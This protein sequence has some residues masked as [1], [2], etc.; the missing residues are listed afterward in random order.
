MSASA[1]LRQGTALNHLDLGKQIRRYVHSGHCPGG[2]CAWVVQP[3]HPKRSIRHSQAIE[4]GG[5]VQEGL[6]RFDVR[7]PNAK[8]LIRALPEVIQRDAQQLTIT[9]V[10]ITGASIEERTLN[11]GAPDP[12]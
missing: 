7:R 10:F 1:P 3:R 4:L 6:H 9:L 11:P 12:D 5:D 2:L 8:I